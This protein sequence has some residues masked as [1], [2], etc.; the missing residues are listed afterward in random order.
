[1]AYLRPVDARGPG[2]SQPFAGVA[3][4]AVPAPGEYRVRIELLHRG[5]PTELVPEPASVRVLDRD[6]EQTFD[7]A[8]DQAEIDAASR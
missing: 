1:M 7:I 5:T 8:L 6:G 2:E 4:F 3:T